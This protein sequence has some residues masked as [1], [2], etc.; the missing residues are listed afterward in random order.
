[1]IVQK[2]SKE[3][4]VFP[5]N[6]KGDPYAWD[7]TNNETWQ[8]IV[9]SDKTALEIFNTN[10]DRTNLVQYNPDWRN[11]TFRFV[12]AEKTSQLAVKMTAKILT[13]KQVM[14]WQFYI[15]DKL[16]GRQS[17]LSSFNTLVIKVRADNSTLAKVSLITNDAL[18][19]SASINA[20]I[21]WKEIRIP[22]SNLQPDS[23]L[24]LPRPY[25]GFLPLWF[26]PNATGNFYIPDAE[27]IQVICY[28]EGKTADLEVA[29][30]WLEK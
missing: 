24:L 17:E 2:A 9:A 19:F 3:Y 23:S 26:K 14:G 28:G 22:F 11:N 10:T 5:G 4:Y 13:D 6:N 1:M 7:N 21:E 8:T 20:G 29:S 16:K 30:M 27:K 18:C 15:G 12:P 25:P